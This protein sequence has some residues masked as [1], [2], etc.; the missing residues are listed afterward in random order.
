MKTVMSLSYCP[1][2][3]SVFLY[4]LHITVEPVAMLL[5]LSAMLVGAG[6]SSMTSLC[7]VGNFAI[8]MIWIFSHHIK[9][10]ARIPYSELY[11]MA[12]P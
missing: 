6:R 5:L 9:N 3:L 8:I 7:Q 1:I 12:H 2:L 11:D 4:F 10:Y